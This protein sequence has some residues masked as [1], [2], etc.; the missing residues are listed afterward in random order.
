MLRMSKLAD[1]GTVV[2]TSMARAP[3]RVQ[4]AAD[5]ALRTGLAMPTVSKLLKTLARNGLLV[6]L[7]GARGGYMLVRSPHEISVAQVIVAI[8]GQI[9]MTEC[10]GA[11][12]LCT[13]ESGC[14]VRANWQKINHVVLRALQQITLEQMTRPMGEIVDLRAMSPPP[15]KRTSALSK[16]ERPEG[17]QT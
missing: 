15:R 8:E 16:A 11:P 9:G 10:S 5:V 3:D 4:S 13:Q 6:S 2:M 7:R 14:S 17:A 12:G 1:Y